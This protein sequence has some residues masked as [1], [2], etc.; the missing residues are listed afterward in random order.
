M[1][2]SVKSKPK[3]RYVPYPSLDDPG[4]NEA[5]ARKYEFNRFVSSGSAPSVTCERSSFS[6]TSQ[7]RIAA[8]FMSP[9]TPYNGLLVFHGTGTGKT[10]TAITIAEQFNTVF[11][12]RH[13]VLCSS[14]LK[15]NFKRQIFDETKENQCTG[16]AYLQ[17]DNPTSQER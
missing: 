10:C 13:Y 6:L 16:S 17:K 3:A 7:Q 15:D 8:A 4:F 14:A 5:I 12:K 2:R 11:Q 9:F 1:T